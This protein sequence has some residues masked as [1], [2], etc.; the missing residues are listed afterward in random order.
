MIFEFFLI[1]FPIFTSIFAAS[2]GKEGSS[3]SSKVDK[4]AVS[5]LDYADIPLS[6]I[7][8]VSLGFFLTL[9]FK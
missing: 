8:K 5:A 2:R 7:R 9:S 3:A 4:T 6:Q 1:L